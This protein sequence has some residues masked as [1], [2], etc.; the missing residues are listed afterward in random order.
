VAACM[1]DARVR[2]REGQAV[3]LVRFVRWPIRFHAR[4][5]VL[6]C[7]ALAAALVAGTAVAIAGAGGGS[8]RSGIAAATSCERPYSSESP[9]NTR[10]GPA[11]PYH[12]RSDFHVSALEG[13]LSSDPTQYTYPVYEVDG[14]TPLRDVR[15]SGVFSEVTHDDRVLRVLKEPVVRMPIPEGAL[16]AAG[17]DG[18][19]I[20]VNRSTGDEWGVWRLRAEAGGWRATNATH[21]NI[22]WD[23]V[24][25]RDEGGR[26]FFARGAGIPY[27]AGLVRACE[28]RRGRI[29]HALAFAYDYPTPDY[30][31]PASKSD[32]KSTD[33]RDLPEG[34]RLQL[35]P[36]LS[37]RTIRSWGCVG[38]CLT[39]ARALQE[40]GMYVVDNGG[41]PKVM[42]E[43]EGTAHWGGL[44]TSTTV[45][46]IPL[47][48]FRL[49]RSCTIVAER[50]RAILRGTEG[51]DVICAGNGGDR[52]L[53][54]GGDD[55]VYAGGGRDVVSAG[56]GA[57]RVF[58]GAGGD[59]ISGGEGR[60]LLLGG[61]GDDV[62]LARDDRRDSVSG[63]TGR[64]RARV[65]PR[66]DRRRGVEIARSS[67]IKHAAKASVPNRP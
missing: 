20:I 46:P 50:P 27:L 4:G 33:P 17:S 21:Y 14:S 58:G 30:V 13:E 62:L 63:G 36:S 23:A 59:R 48:R 24:P 32:G 38:P 49:V 65:D 25:P 9:W 19:L 64:D 53:A 40:Y 22:R 3:I 51:D 52:V 29:E 56:A 37:E 1:K 41:R 12:P 44:V 60:D 16:P 26:P 39:I 45:R 15:V 47:S 57:D 34:S 5:G 55:V 42:L 7:V 8:A 6:L 66:I 2:G 31:H 11:P 18:Q 35:D 43:Y 54:G 67:A 61:G 28:I 10:I